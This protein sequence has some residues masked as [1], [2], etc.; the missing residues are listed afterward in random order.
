MSL[1]IV[2]LLSILFSA[3]VL[4]P[5]GAHLM[6]LPNKIGMSASDYLVAQRAYDGWSLSA[7]GVIAALLSTGTFAWLARREPDVFTLAVMAFACIVATQVV[8]WTLNFP[9]NQQTANWTRLPGNWESLRQRW[10]IGH[11][12]SCVLNVGALLALLAANWR[13]LRH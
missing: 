8:F 9:G 1:R 3:L 4:V 11:A 5:A 12:T 13:L 2:L 6:S 7:L 10:E